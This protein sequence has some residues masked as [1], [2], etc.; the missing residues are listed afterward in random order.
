MAPIRIGFI[1]LSAN[2]DDAWANYSHLPYLQSPAGKEKYT[3][4]ALANTS[5]EAALKAIEAFKLPASTKAYGSPED[6]AADPNVDL[7]V[8]SV[9]VNDHYKLIKP[10]LLAGKDA[11]VEWPLSRNLDEVK[12]LHALAKEHGSKTIV[13]LQGRFDPLADQLR[14]IIQSGK[15]GDVLSATFT[16]HCAI[17]GSSIPKTAEY[18]LDSKAGGNL[19]TILLSHSE[20]LFLAASVQNN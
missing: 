11:Y 19:A 4:V 14:S 6:L 9:N 12:E 18:V 1:G 15:I 8:V 13:G 16:I 10:A 17:F 3:I 2:R 5:A 7:V 20:P